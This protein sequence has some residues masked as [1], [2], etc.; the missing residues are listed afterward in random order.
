[1]RMNISVPDDLAADVRA[2][3]LPVSALCQRALR[4][5]V[6]RLRSA[7]LLGMQRLKVIAGDPLTEVSFTGRWLID[8][9]AERDKTPALYVYYGVAITAR[10]QFAVYTA[11]DDLQYGNELKAYG[12]LP[13][14]ARDGVPA[15]IINRATAVLG[16]QHGIQLDI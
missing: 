10:G 14:A 8:P 15:D 16:L 9:Y 2:L 4:E 6:N 3:G 12:T 11:S 13:E 1:M 5:E 7:E